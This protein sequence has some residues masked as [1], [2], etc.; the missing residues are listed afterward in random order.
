MFTCKGTTI[1]WTEYAVYI[2]N[3]P[4]YSVD[5]VAVT[6]RWNIDWSVSLCICKQFCC[7]TAATG[8]AYSTRVKTLT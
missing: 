8:Y 5:E 1:V 7:S 2:V 6:L 3:V 4:I